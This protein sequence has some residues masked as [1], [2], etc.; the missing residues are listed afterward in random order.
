MNIEKVIQLIEENS[1]VYAILKNC[2]YRILK[3]WSIQDYQQ[4][5]IVLR[6]GETVDSF[7]IIVK[8]KAN[9]YMMSESGKK[10]SQVIYQNGDFI[11]EL[12]IFDHLPSA[13]FVEALSD[14]TLIRIQADDFMDWIA[15]DTHMSQYFNRNLAKYL[16]NLSKKAGMDSLYSLRHRLCNY[17]INHMNPYQEGQ[18]IVRMSRSQISDHLAVTSR[19]VNRVLYNWKEQGIVGIESDSIIILDI[20]Q[21]NEEKE[22]SL[23]E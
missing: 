7:C 5:D 18:F 3:K 2:P 19:S 13:C 9:I 22:N 4:G 21:L 12:E 23:L 1:H 15:V 17:L 6:Q 14:L 8:G 20:D 10:Y 16:Y 11:G